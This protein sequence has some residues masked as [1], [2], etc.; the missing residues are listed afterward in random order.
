M[1]LSIVK[2]IIYFNFNYI[3]FM[4]IIY[5]SKFIFIH[6]ICVFILTLVKNGKISNE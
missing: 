2:Q 5:E 6:S 3:Q 1:N 4:C